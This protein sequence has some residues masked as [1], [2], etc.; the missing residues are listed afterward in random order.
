MYQ[1]FVLDFN[2]QAMNRFVEHR[3]LITFKELWDDCHWHF[4]KY[5]DLDET[6]ANPPNLLVGCDED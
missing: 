2:D 6:C 1:F 4:K 5:S 3:M